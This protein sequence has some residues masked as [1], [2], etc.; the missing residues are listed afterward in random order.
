MDLKEIRDEIDVI[1]AQ[2]SQL[3]Q[4]RLQLTKQVAAYKMEHKKPIYDPVREEEKLTALEGH[5]D[6]PDVKNDL[7]ELF[8]LIMSMSRR[9]QKRIMENE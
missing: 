4:K 6:D 3:Y 5:A 7:R 8:T 1:D 9:D 2:I